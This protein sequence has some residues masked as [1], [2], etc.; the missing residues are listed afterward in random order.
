MKQNGKENVGESR[1]PCT[2]CHV[3]VSQV[4]L[5]GSA[6]WVASVQQRSCH[7]STEATKEMAKLLQG[8]HKNVLKV[9]KDKKYQYDCNIKY[10]YILNRQKGKN[11]ITEEVILTWF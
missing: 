2:C 6:A 1:N 8:N 3:V 11:C 9:V 7:G 5:S 10:A 4:T